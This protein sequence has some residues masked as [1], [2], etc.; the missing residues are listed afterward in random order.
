MATKVSGKKLER[1]PYGS[2]TSPDPRVR[3]LCAGGGTIKVTLGPVR[4]LNFD[5][6][7]HQHKGH[8]PELTGKRGKGQ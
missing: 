7:S 2:W 1:G 4:K 5:V 3:S 8:L 6:G